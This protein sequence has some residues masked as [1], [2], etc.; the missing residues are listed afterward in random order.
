MLKQ[1]RL[2]AFDMNCVAHSPQMWLAAMAHVLICALR[3]IALQQRRDP[4]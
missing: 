4:I 1:I 2:N 3:R